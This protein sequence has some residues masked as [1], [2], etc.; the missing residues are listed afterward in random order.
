MDAKAYEP[1]ELALDS[2]TCD[3]CVYV[4]TCP[5]HHQDKPATCGSFQWRAN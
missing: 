2:Y 5:K 3:D 4:N 1:G